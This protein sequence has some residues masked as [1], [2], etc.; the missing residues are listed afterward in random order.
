[1]V[2]FGIR[3]VELSGSNVSKFVSCSK[4]LN[5]SCSGNFFLCSEKKHGDC[6]KFV[7][8]LLLPTDKQ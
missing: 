7:F 5:F 6:M 2:G 4:L 8:S 3:C 1:M